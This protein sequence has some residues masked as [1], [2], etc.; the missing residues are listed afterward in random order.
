MTDEHKMFRE[1]VRKFFKNELVPNLPKWREQGVVDQ[2]FWLKAGQAGLLSSAIPEAYGGYGA[3]CG[4]EA[5]IAQEQMSVGD[6]C[7]AWSIH[8]ICT[9]YILAFCSDDQKARWLPKLAT[10]EFIPALCMSEPVAGSDLQ[11]LQTYAAE[12]G[13]GYRI[14]GSKT[15]ISNGQSANFLIVAAKTGRPVRGTDITLFALSTDELAGFERGRRLKKIG[16]PGQDTSELFFDQVFVDR[17]NVVGEPGQGFRL[18]MNQLPWERLIIALG[19]VGYSDLMMRETITYVKARRAFQKRLMDFQNTRFKLAECQTKLEVTRAFV[20]KCVEEM[21]GGSLTNA[22]ASM[23]KWWAAQV[24]CEIADECLQLHG[25]YGYIF[26]Y[27]IAH[28]YADSRIQQIY[29]GSREIM[30]ELIARTIDV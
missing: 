8:S 20:D 3:D 13:A 18:L 17:S 22:S 7:W 14:S 26:D 4:F 16:L 27:P 11:A 30:K 23:A 10:G 2:D 19:A 24:Q 12:D 6:N 5:I 15:F 1:S 25:G 29:G 21:I 9:H 28:A